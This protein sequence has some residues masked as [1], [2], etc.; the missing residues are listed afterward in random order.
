MSPKETHITNAFYNEK[1]KLERYI[2]K[3]VP[4]NEDAEDIVQDVFLSFASGFDDI[5]DLSS[6]L[7]WLYSVARKKIIDFKRKKKTLRIEDTKT[8]SP[9]TD[10]PLLIADIIPVIESSPDEE[11]MQKLIWDQI[12]INL[13]LLPEKQREVF[14]MHELDGLSFDQIAEITGENLNTLISRKRYAVIFLRE[15]LS[16]LMEIVKY[17]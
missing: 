15:K 6:T 5:I 13:D 14:I 8:T 17:K 10:E 7:S 3:S 9:N 12:Q 11:M 4:T 16:E 2:R 1:Q